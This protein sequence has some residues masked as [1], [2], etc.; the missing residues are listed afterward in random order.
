MKTLVKFLTQ[1]PGDWEWGELVIGG[2]VQMD[3]GIIQFNGGTLIVS[4]GKDTVIKRSN[5]RTFKS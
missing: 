5:K 2:F 4:Y 3:E 1:S